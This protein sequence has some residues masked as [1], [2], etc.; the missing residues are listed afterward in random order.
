MDERRWVDRW[1][2]PLHRTLRAGACDLTPDER[3]GLPVG[4]EV[5]LIT[6]EN[7]FRELQQIMLESVTR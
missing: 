6:P 1:R 7:V 4:H 5:A 2:R 3:R